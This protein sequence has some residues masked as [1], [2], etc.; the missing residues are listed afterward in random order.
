MDKPLHKLINHAALQHLRRMP[1]CC[2]GNV[3]TAP[4]LRAICH[5]GKDRN[6]E[7]LRSL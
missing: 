7:I 6:T 1:T 4:S 3:D 2:L 5:D